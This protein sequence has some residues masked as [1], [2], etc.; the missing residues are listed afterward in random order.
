[1]GAVFARALGHVKIVLRPRPPPR[2]LD[3][4]PGACRERRRRFTIVEEI[5]AKRGNWPILSAVLRSP[6]SFRFIP[7][8]I[9]RSPIYSRLHSYPD[10]V[11]V[12]RPEV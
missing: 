1:M 9:F 2:L 3:A 11:L 4:L 5:V 12:S 10:F 8:T 6:E 7:C